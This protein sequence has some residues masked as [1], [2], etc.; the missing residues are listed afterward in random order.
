M[1]WCCSLTTVC[2]GREEVLGVYSRARSTGAGSRL[3]PWDQKCLACTPGGAGSRR[4]PWGRTC[5]ACI[6]GPR[7]CP[8]PPGTASAMM[9]CEF[10]VL[11]PKG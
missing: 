4:H 5:L 11:S 2:D 6:P 1:V 8:D 3:H 9:W 7:S 10:F